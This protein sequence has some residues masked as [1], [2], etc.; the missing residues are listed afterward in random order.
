MYL[1]LAMLGLHCCVGFSLAAVSRGY[2]LVVMCQPFICRDFSCCRARALGHAG[3]SSCGSQTLEHKLNNWHAGLAAPQPVGSSKIR[4][5]TCVSWQVDSL[6]LSHQGIP[7][8]LFLSSESFQFS[9]HKS[10]ARE[11]GFHNTI[12]PQQ[13]DVP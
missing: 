4:N 10:N 1:F 2:S 13:H 5:Q 12:F 9:Q 11:M 6:P 8:W 3:F 7:Q